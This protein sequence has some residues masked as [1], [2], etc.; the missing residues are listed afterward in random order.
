M[1]YK[2]N[3]NPA[4][5]STNS[6]FPFEDEHFSLIFFWVEGLKVL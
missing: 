4:I 2:T 1:L 5:P 3:I 6:N